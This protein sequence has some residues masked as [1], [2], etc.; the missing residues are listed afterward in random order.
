MSKDYRVPSRSEIRKQKQ[1]K[2]I[3]KLYFF[4]FILVFLIFF[5]FFGCTKVLGVEQW[6]TFDPEKLT[7]IE[8]TS[9]I[10]DQDDQLVHQIHGPENRIKVSIDQVPKHVRDAFIAVEDVRFYQHKGFDLKRIIGALWADIK[11]GGFK[12][13]ASTISQQVIRNS[14]L[15]TEKTISR[16]VQ[17]IFLAYQLENTYEKDEILEMYL[18]IIY[19]GNGAYGVE[20]ASQAYFGKSVSQLTL[21]EGALLAG[22]P[23]SPSKYSPH[24][25]LEQSIQRR[26]LILELMEKHGFITSDEAEKAKKS[27]VELVKSNK[28]DYPYGFFTDQVIR[29]AAKV[30][31]IEE[32]KLYTGGYKIFT[33]L[34]RELQTFCEELYTKDDLFPPSKDKVPIESALVIIDPKTGGIKALIG[35]REHTAKLGFNRATQMQRQPGSAIKPILV[36]GPAIEKH[37]YTPVTFILD[38]PTTIGDYTPSNAG[39]KYNGWIT[40][41]YA[42]AR[43]INIP[44][45]K[46]LNDI[47]IETGKRFAEQVN[48]PLHPEDKYLS[49]ALGGFYKGVS[50][51]ELCNAY[52]PFANNGKFSTATT[53]RY[54]E[55]AKGEK[56]YEYIPEWKQVMDDENAFIMT[57]ILQSTIQWGTG[58]RLN[59]LGIPLAGK[60]GTVQLPNEGAFRNIKGNKDAWMVAYNPDYLA[61]VWI[62]YD[63]TDKKHYLPSNATGGSYPAEILKEVFRFLYKDKEAPDFQEP[64]GIIKAKIDAKSLLERRKVML[65]NALTPEEFQ[66]EEVFTQSTLPDQETDY[67]IIPQPPNDIVIEI[68]QENKPIISFTPVNSFA[69]YRIYRQRNMSPPILIGERSD[70]SLHRIQIKDYLAVPGEKYEYYIIPVHPEIIIDN[71]PLEGPASERIPFEIPFLFPQYQEEEQENMIHSND[72]IEDDI[73]SSGDEA[74]E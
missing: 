56:I 58:I 62:G 47:G 9:Q 57:N 61:T 23:K 51:L 15:T 55:N 53:I 17:E 67:W 28:G 40:L 50:P 24:I 45:V 48:I 38:E 74:A 27:K 64:P 26:N 70:S 11:A 49:L 14:H 66:M 30:L 7:N 68:S 29:D 60:T 63:Q 5:T 52:M 13:G 73:E 35:G 8:Q 71:E 32:E 6:K 20:A 41:R 33:T 46:V 3:N 31:D 2:N 18:N 10:Y 54:I 65:A 59:E 19:L 39:G 43:S 69:I 44:A 36:Y 42:V 4:L 22:I 1:A 72:D 16:K 25:N 37:G 21:A 34:D 12:E